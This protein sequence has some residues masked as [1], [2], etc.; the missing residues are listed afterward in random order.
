MDSRGI[1]VEAKVLHLEV[2]QEGQEVRGVRVVWETQSEVH[3]ERRT[4]VEAQARQE[5]QE[6]VAPDRVGVVDLR[7]EV[8]C[9]RSVVQALG[10][11]HQRREQEGLR[12]G[13]GSEEHNLRSSGHSTGLPR[14]E[15]RDILGTV[16]RRGRHSVPVRP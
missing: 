1:R 15:H 10:Q 2:V 13:Q 11:L 9:L 16:R 8:E 7:M 4:A 12:T 14:T 6:S 5:G 3:Q